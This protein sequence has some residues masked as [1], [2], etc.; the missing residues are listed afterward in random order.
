MTIVN[1]PLRNCDNNLEG[2][3]HAETIDL[4]NDED[5]FECFSYVNKELDESLRKKFGT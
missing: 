5:T 4:N 1:C 2:I 3:C